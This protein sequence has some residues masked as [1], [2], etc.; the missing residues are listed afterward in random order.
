MNWQLI[1]DS[2]P[3]LLE[4]A[5]MTLLLTA[6]AMAFGFCV[7]VPLA[8]AKM[9]ANRLLSWPAGLYVYVFRGTPLLLQLFLVY[10][11]LGQFSADLEAAGV[12]WFFRDEFNCAV[13][14]LVLNTSAYSA[15]I[16]RG[17]IQAVPI[18]EI[19]AA[20]AV[21]MGR[22]LQ[23]R[24]I[25][26]PKALRLVWPAYTNEVVFLMQATSLVSLITVTDLFR[27][28]AQVARRSFAIY[29]MYIAAGVIYLLISYAIILAFGRIEK[30]LNRHLPGRP[31][32]GRWLA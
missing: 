16:F 27:V 20:R 17:G 26:L 5:R 32:A 29:E 1:A 31:G 11:G 30:R 12:W 15:E 25:V 23:L 24:R 9:S 14:V 3:A 13:L 28:A 10:F 18:G 21:G 2:L 7:A 19:E 8:L 22:F 6:L 4:G